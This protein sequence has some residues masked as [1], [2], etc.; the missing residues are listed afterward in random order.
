MSHLASFSLLTTFS[1]MSSQTDVA[2]WLSQ[3]LRVASQQT[4]E[5]KQ[6]ALRSFA[7]VGYTQKAY[8]VQTISAGAKIWQA[9]LKLAIKAS[10]L[11]P[12]ASRWGRNDVSLRWLR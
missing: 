6:V 9:L 10:S 7:E 2:R 8:E 11:S 12:V 3:A 5:I 4:N 1:V